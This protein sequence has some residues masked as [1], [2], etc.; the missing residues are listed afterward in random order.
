[1]AGDRP[2]GLLLV[3]L[4]GDVPGCVSTSWDASRACS[5]YPAAFWASPWVCRPVL[6]VAAPSSDPGHRRQWQGVVTSRHLP[7]RGGRRPGGPSDHGRAPVQQKPENR[8]AVF[9]AGTRAVR[10]G[11]RPRGPVEQPGMALTLPAAPS[12]PS[13]GGRNADVGY[14]LRHRVFGGGAVQCSSR[15]GQDARRRCHRLRS[16]RRADRS[17]RRD[18]RGRGIGRARQ[19]SGQELPGMVVCFYERACTKCAPFTDWK[20]A[21]FGGEHLSQFAERGL[22]VHGRHVPW[23]MMSQVDTTSP[24][25]SVAH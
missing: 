20:G 14:R 13:R 15:H 5:A 19:E 17:T 24:S 1:M 21:P 22:R 10:A 3:G 9:G 11:A 23:E 25:W 12:P 6:P 16:G 4:V 8:G 18:R 7:D 2:F